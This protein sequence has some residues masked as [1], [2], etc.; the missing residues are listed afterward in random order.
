M[1]ASS[2][3]PRLRETEKTFFSSSLSFPEIPR[4]A[5]VWSTCTYNRQH[6]PASADKNQS[7][8]KER[9]CLLSFIKR[10][11]VRAG[12]CMCVICAFLRV[13]Q[14]AVVVSLES[15]TP[16][17]KATG[18]FCQCERQERKCMLLNKHTCTR[19]RTHISVKNCIFS[20]IF[21][22]RRNDI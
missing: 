1:T 14:T 19:V 11:I 6:L 22:L 20:W 17:V 2:A 21:Y 18:M 13:R 10:L 4:S 8:P 3:D 15:K 5:F 12:A 16:A 9:G 7:S